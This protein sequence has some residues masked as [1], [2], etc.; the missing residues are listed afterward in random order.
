V[1]LFCGRCHNEKNFATYYTEGCRFSVFDCAPLKSIC[2]LAIDFS[3]WENGAPLYLQPSMG[4]PFIQ[5]AS[6]LL[7]VVGN[8]EPLSLERDLVFV[9]P[10]QQ[11]M[12]TKY[13]LPKERKTNTAF[14]I[15]WRQL[16]LEI[17]L[18]MKDCKTKRAFD[19]EDLT[20]SLSII[21][22]ISESLFTILQKKDGLKTKLMT[23]SM[24]ENCMTCKWMNLY[25]KER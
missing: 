18:E 21:P 14:L 25:A 2:Q 8:F 10:S 9:T 23:N 20:K 19:R 24:I 15:T 16:E 4:L 6:E 7:L 3:M 17:E 13:A 1:E 12:H 22:I 5:N 11:P